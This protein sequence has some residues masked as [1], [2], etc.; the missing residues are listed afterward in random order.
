MANILEE[1][2]KGGSCTI[3]LHNVWRKY[4]TEQKR[5]DQRKRMASHSIPVE[6]FSPAKLRSTEKNHVIVCRPTAQAAT[7][8][9]KAKIQKNAQT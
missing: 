9:E 5:I 8:P 4:Y 2:Q 6:H 1:I 3:K 7:R